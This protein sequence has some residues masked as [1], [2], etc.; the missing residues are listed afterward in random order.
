MHMRVIAYIGNV[1]NRR[2][3]D[4]GIPH[5]A[6]GFVTRAGFGPVLDHV[7]DFGFPIMPFE[8]SFVV[9]VPPQVLAPDNLQHPVPMR[10]RHAHHGD[11]AVTA[12]VSPVG[13]G[14]GR[15]LVAPAR[16]QLAGIMVGGKFAAQRKIHRLNHRRFNE[17]PLARRVTPK[18]R[19]QDAGI[20]V[21]TAHDVDRRAAGPRRWTARFPGNAH[22]PAGRLDG[23]IHGK[24]VPVGAGEAVTG[25]GGIYQPRIDFPHHRPAQ[26]Q[27]VHSARR[28]IFQQD[29]GLLRHFLQDFLAAQRLQ[30][31]RHAFLVGI[32]HGECH[33]RLFALPAYPVAVMR[34]HLDHLRAGH[35]HQERR[36]RT[37]VNL[38]QVQDPDTVQ[39]LHD[40]RP[41]P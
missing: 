31:D 32:E 6:E 9:R 24:L 20:H 21:D 34:L 38:R 1:P 10:L 8:V 18:Q 28:E 35:G 41:P 37:L 16:R 4:P 25:G 40:L 3:G 27:P 23:M 33:R 39:R 36:V 7:V 22:Q 29:V 19:L 15:R 11:P 5:L 13:S 26:S 17:R 12:A 14:D 2:D 30:V